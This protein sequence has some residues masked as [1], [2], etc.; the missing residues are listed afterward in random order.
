MLLNIQHGGRL[1]SRKY[2]KH[3]ISEIIWAYFIRILVCWCIILL[4]RLSA[5]ECTVTDN[6]TAN[7]NDE[8]CSLSIALTALDQK[9]QNKVILLSITFTF[10]RRDGG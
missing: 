9:Q 10:R 7:I 1:P 2:K 8:N 3:D 5:I 4:R 6:K